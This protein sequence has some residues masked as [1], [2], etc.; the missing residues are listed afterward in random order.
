MKKKFEAFLNE[1]GHI[2]AYWKFSFE[3]ETWFGDNYNQLLKEDPVK[4]N[5]LNDLPDILASY[6]T[7]PEAGVLSG[8][9]FYNKIKD[10][11][12][13]MLNAH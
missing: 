4:T 13:K 1:K 7:E 10:I 2:D 12:E 11:Y 8:E 9:D 6:D 5:L 3:M